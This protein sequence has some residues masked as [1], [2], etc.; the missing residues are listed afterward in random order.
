[1]AEYILSMGRGKRNRKASPEAV[2][3]ASGGMVWS[4]GEEGKLRAGRRGGLVCW[5]DSEVSGVA[6][7]Q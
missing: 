2:A 1:M 3:K 4:V 7:S 6:G 5:E